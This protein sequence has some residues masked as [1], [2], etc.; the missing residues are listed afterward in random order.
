VTNNSRSG[1]RHTEQALSVRL[2]PDRALLELLAS[3]RYP[4]EEKADTGVRRLV[5]EA[6]AV[7]VKRQAAEDMEFRLAAIELMGAEVKLS[8][9]ESGTDTERERK[10]ATAT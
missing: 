5:K 4:D 3:M 8:Q 6:V 7:F 10:G 1:D 2:G 9:T